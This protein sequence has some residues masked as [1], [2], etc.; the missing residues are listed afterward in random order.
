MMNDLLTGTKLMAF[1]YDGTLAPATGIP[2]ERM[3]AA[4]YQANQNGCTLVLVTGRV[5]SMLPPSVTRLPFAFFITSNG[6]RVTEAGTLKTLSC[7]PLPKEVALTVLGTLQEQHAVCNVFI[8][9]S[10]YFDVSCFRVLRGIPSFNFFS[11]IKRLVDF[12]NHTHIVKDVRQTVERT[13]GN[14]EKIV[15]TFAHV[16]ECQQ[17]LQ[18][19]AQTQTIESAST[20]GTDLEITAHG[21]TKGKS[22]EV[23][24]QK[25]G[26][27]KQ[28]VIA[29]GD[30]GNDLSMTETA[31][32]FIAPLNATAEIRTL[33]NRIVP[34][35]EEDG[36]AQVIEEI[37]R[38]C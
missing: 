4:L 28:Q 15:G 9:G 31:G 16:D 21:I 18:L 11:R 13:Q 26:F 3:I 24:Y 33:A 38:T 7:T 35:V 10:A 37:Y 25:L 27:T 22:L 5:F 30:S 14:I 1:D 36:V 2:S 12:L 17:T 29:F 34:D 32:Y 6:A 19:F 23:L 20:Q 8:D